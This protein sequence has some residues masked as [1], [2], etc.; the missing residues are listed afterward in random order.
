MKNTLFQICKA[1]V[2]LALLWCCFLFAGCYTKRQAIEKFCTKTTADTTIIKHDTIVLDSTRIDSV[3]SSRIDSIYI[4]E[5]KLSIK[6]V[7][8]RDSVYLSGKYEADTIYRTDTIR[9][10]IPITVPNC[11]RTWMETVHA[12]R[13]WLLFAFVVGFALAMYI[14]LRS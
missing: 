11:E 13:Y 7:K 1:T 2:I 4:K 5:G 10:S 12:A 3:F 8:I 14:K 6:Y 9:V